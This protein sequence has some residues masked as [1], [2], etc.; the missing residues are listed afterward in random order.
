[1]KI[2]DGNRTMIIEM[3]RWS[4]ADAGYVDDI[5]EAY[6]NAESLPYDSS[7]KAYIVDDVVKY[8]DLAFDWEKEAIKTDDS[9]KA[10]ITEF[11]KE[12]YL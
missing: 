12:S 7:K 9:S 4:C 10:C 11:Y 6:F 5:S 1:M 2:T 8:M 3:V